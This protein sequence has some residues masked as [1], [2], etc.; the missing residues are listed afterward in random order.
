MRDRIGCAAEPVDFGQ[1]GAGLL[2]QLFGL[3]LDDMAAVENILEFQEIRL[4]GQDLLQAQ[5]PLLVP[6]ARK[7]H[8]LVPRGQLQRAAAGALG[9]RHR[10]RLDQDTVDVVLRL[11]LGQAQRVYLH[12]IAE[13]QCLGV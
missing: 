1:R 7:A 9:Q 5:A 13:E 2:F 8:G 10:Q 11:R 4:V 12:P 3:A 6:R